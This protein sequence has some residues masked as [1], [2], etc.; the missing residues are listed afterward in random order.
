MNAAEDMQHKLTGEKEAQPEKH[1]QEVHRITTDIID[2]E[3]GQRIGQKI[4]ATV[5][6][7]NT[8]DGV[9]SKADGITPGF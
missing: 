8:P 7:L 3:T 5:N 2:E 1:L 9:A 4:T 6:P